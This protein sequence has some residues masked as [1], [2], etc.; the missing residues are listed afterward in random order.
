MTNYSDTERTDPALGSMMTSV[1]SGKS[2]KDL[3]F[4]EKAF[5]AQMRRV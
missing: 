3:E 4:T 1:L 2:K 5:L